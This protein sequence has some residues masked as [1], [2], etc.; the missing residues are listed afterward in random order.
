MFSRKDIYNPRAFNVQNFQYIKDP[1]DAI[2]T[3]YAVLLS[4]AGYVRKKAALLLLKA[5]VIIDFLNVLIQD[6]VAPISRND[7]RV[8]EW[9][10]RVKK[11]GSCERCGATDNLEAHH[12]IGWADY[13]TGRA[14]IGNG[15][16]LC[17]NCHAKAHEGER[18]E[19][20]IRSKGAGKNPGKR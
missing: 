9:V 7:P 20:L 10:R 14:D 5:F 18:A 15:V 17:V 19:N 13:P 12:I 11:V 16:C 2:V 4:D 3:A 8:A 1:Y 6:D